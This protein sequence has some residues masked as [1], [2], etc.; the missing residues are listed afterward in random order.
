MTVMDLYFKRKRKERGDVPDVYQ[1]EELPDALKVQVVHIWNDTFGDRHA[2]EAGAPHNT[3]AR[4]S[5]ILARELG[6]FH[7]RGPR[8]TAGS[9]YDEWVGYFLETEDLDIELSMIE[10]G[11]HGIENIT[12]RYEYRHIPNSHV[13]AKEAIE[14]LNDRF[15]E[16]GVG[17]QYSNGRII[18]VDSQF[19]H[20]EAVKP[21]LALLNAAEYAG[22][23]A[24]FLK[25]HEAYRHGDT[26]HALAESLKAL[27]SV[28]KS[29]CK[30]K[31]WTVDRNAT[32]KAL[33]GVLFDRGL[34][35][36]YWQSHFGGLRT[37]L[38]SGVP[39]ARN[40][41]GGHGQ[42]ASVT[43]VPGYLAAYVLHQTAAA[44]V[45]LVEAER[46]TPS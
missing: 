36:A 35:P 46:A 43:T 23:E 37:T 27:E 40:K 24:E 42:G 44:I 45:F 12:S 25:A 2:A 29:I 33:I 5:A 21:A 18:R 22:A 6:E 28:M 1:Y 26:K 20:A 15:Q 31:K 39:T 34:I 16:H 19:L 14:E 8:R 17:F 11:G 7:L 4:M 10:L 38:E 9:S 13:R 3:Y 41:D 30:K 32:S